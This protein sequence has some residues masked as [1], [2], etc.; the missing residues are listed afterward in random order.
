MQVGF[1]ALGGLNLRELGASVV[2]LQHI[3]AV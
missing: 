1:I 3:D 2:V